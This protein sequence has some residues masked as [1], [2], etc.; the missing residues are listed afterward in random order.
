MEFDFD[1]FFSS[2]PVHQ[3]FAVLLLSSHN[4]R[5]MTKFAVFMAT[6][7]ADTGPV[8]VSV[9]RS[10]THKV[11]G[12]E[13]LCFDVVHSDAVLLHQDLN[14]SVHVHL[15]R[16]LFN[17]PVALQRTG[18]DGVSVQV[19]PGLC[20]EDELSDISRGSVFDR[21]WTSGGCISSECCTALPP[22]AF[23]A[24]GGSGQAGSETFCSAGGSFFLFF[25][26]CNRPVSRAYLFLFQIFCQQQ[27]KENIIKK[28][29]Y[30]IITQTN[31]VQ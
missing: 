21:S 19:A 12:H 7:T 20:V 30:N 14:V 27:K 18:A 3:R 31:C 9:W 25:L 28:H 13:E 2:V 5:H 6:L 8:R 11:I 17:L 22:A 16:G 10:K 29:N 23:P 4:L 15:L 1:G 26:W 24:P